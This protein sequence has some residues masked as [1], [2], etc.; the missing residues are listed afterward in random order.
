MNC[1]VNIPSN[2]FGT[3]VALCLT[4]VCIMTNWFIKERKHEREKRCERAREMC[5]TEI[6]FNIP[7]TLTHW[8]KSTFSRILSNKP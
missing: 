5:S 8:F 6:N 4:S 1:L 7:T 3:K 2:N